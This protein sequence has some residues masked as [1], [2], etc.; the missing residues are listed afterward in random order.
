[1]AFKG[2]R[3]V[4]KPSKVPKMGTSM[5]KV[6]KK[7]I[8]KAKYRQL[9]K[10]IKHVVH[11]EQETKLVSNLSVAEIINIPGAGLNTSTLGYLNALTPVVSVGTAANQRIGNRIR[12]VK[13]SFRYTIN[14][15]PTTDAGSVSNI[16]PFRGL[17]FF[18]K[19]IVYRHKYNRG[20]NDP[21]AI[22]ETG[23]TN[24]PLTNVV[25]TYFRPYNRDEYEIAYSALHKLSACRHIT[26]S[27]GYTDNSNDAKMT[28][29]I[30]RKASIKMP[31]QITFNDS[32][33]QPTNLNWWIGFA[34]CNV[35]GSTISTSQYRATVNCESFLYFQD[36]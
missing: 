9:A 19:V 14:A 15:L 16:N 24:F 29:F 3:R 27:V 20:D 11:K 31:K 12:P 35:D 33:T 13:L 21:S 26:A 1:M 23:G 34:V 8:N 25:D 7:A 30:V 18:V 28:S 6:V 22:M 17:P 4:A 10:V 2:R 36:D 32:N 5:K